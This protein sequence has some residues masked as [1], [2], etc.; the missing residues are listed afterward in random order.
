[1]SIIQRIRNRMGAKDAEIE[2]LSK[3][4]EALTEHNLKLAA[5]NKLASDEN[6]R[7]KREMRKLDKALQEFADFADEVDP[8]A[9]AEEVSAEAV[10]PVA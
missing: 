7:L 1:M 5:D 10:E 9:P 2:R 8:P 4:N 3:A 6:A